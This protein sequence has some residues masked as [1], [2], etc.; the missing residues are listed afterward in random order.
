MNIPP[1]TQPIRIWDLPTRLFHWSLVLLVAAA[2]ATAELA[3]DL[4]DY[5]MLA[6][7]GIL[8]LVLFRFAWGFVGSAHSR[9]A[10]FVRGP[11]A[12]MA[13]LRQMKSG[14]PLHHHG[15]NPLGG[16]MVV[17]LLISL[18]LQAGTGLFANDDIMTE[19]PLKH[20]VSDDT[21]SLLTSIHH[22]NFNILLGLV[23]LHIS[24]ILF[25]RFFKGE[26][27][28]RPMVTG[29]KPLPTGTPTPKAAP[30]W[31]AALI[32][33]GASALVWGMVNYL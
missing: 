1:A 26:N 29:Y 5:H 33:A 24:A 11:G 30:A 22:A 4:M 14:S 21:S 10:D 23:A 31:L 15:H 20:W 6:G 3:D 16:W 2:W 18:L 32:L 12:A 7:Y 17:I 9:F 19:G 25:Y 13:Y 8:A 28:V 27:L